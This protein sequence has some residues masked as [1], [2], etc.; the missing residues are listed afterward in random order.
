MW[1]LEEQHRIT[2][3]NTASM[4]TPVEFPNC[5]QLFQVVVLAIFFFSGGEERDSHKAD[6]RERGAHH[7]EKRS[8]PPLCPFSVGKSDKQVP[9]FPAAR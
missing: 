4:Q 5:I 6:Q 8:F 9:A 1:S 2:H 3:R 7:S